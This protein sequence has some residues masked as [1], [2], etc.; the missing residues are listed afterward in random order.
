MKGEYVYELP[1]S[2][3]EY[4]NNIQLTGYGTNIGGIYYQII[5]DEEINSVSQQLKTEL[6]INE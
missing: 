1:Y 5:P 6:G 4:T 3:N 2:L